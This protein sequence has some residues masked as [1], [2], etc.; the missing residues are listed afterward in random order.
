MASG[1]RLEGRLQMGERLHAIDLCG[2]DQ[3]GDAGPGATA[4]VMPCEERNLFRQGNR[5]DQVL[6]GVGVNLDAAVMQEGLQ[7]AP[8]AMN[9]GQLLAQ[10]RLDRDTR[11]LRLQPVTE[12]GDE[13]RV[14]RS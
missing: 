10:A 7:T 2:G 9:V 4:F 5:A 12:I 6:D 3:G 1:D 11:A 13:G 14:S 8:L